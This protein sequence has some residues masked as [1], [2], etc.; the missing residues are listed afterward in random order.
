[1]TDRLREDRYC[2]WDWHLIILLCLGIV[3]GDDVF[4]E[5]YLLGVLKF[6]ALELE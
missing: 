3:N 5:D 6:E 2:S 1:M 4:V